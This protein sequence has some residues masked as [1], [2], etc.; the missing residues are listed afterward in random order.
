MLAIH[1][2]LTSEVMVIVFLSSEKYHSNTSEIKKSSCFYLLLP[3][4]KYYD[5]RYTLHIHI[6]HV[7]FNILGHFV[8]V[9][10]CN[11]GFSTNHIK[12][13][14]ATLEYAVCRV[15]VHYTTAAPRK[16][17]YGIHKYPF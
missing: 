9:S 11:S 4:F 8:R 2:S 12:L 6:I 5:R 1:V 10:A 13:S 14:A 17:H 7:L 16:L 15:A 3:C